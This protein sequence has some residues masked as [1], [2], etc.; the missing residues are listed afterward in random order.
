MDLQK[1]HEFS[2]FRTFFVRDFRYSFDIWYIAL[3]YQDTDQVRLW[4]WSSFRYSFDIWYIALAYQDTDQVRLWVWSIDFLR[5]YGPWTYKNITNS[6]FSA[7][8]SFVLSDIHWNLVHCFAILRYISSS[9]LVFIHWFFTKLWP[10]D[11]EKYH[12]F[13]VFRTFFFRAVRYSFDIWYIALP[14]R[15]TDQVRLWFWFIYFSRSYGQMDLQKYH[16]FSVF[17]T[18]FVRAFRYSF[19][20][21]YIALP[22]QDTDQV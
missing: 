8:F 20:I 21:W 4:F 15:Y 13:S 18:F 12:E 3:P 19:D 10:L 5:S 14:Y 22:Y 9:S 16:E 1:Y 17:R 7:L 11:L 6:Q 2:V